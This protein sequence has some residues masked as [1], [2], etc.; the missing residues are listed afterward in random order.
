MSIR[1]EIVSIFHMIHRPHRPHL[2]CRKYHQMTSLIQVQ[3]KPNHPRF[4]L[5]ESLIIK[6]RP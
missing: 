1:H 2:T 3:E 5:D 4:R 6:K